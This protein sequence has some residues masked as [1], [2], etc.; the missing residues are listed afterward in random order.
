MRT[1][2]TIPDD[3]YCEV[4]GFGREKNASR[5][6]VQALREFL[7]QKRAKQLMAKAG[8]VPL[9]IDAKKLR[10]LRNAR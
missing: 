3:L 6:V 4:S 7:R 1:T 5:T 10:E 8:K 2:I 9:S